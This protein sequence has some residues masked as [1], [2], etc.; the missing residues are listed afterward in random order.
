MSE[1]WQVPD[2]LRSILGYGTVSPLTGSVPLYDYE[3]ARR[4]RVAK[5]EAPEA[6]LS[7]L[8]IDE[9][10]VAE[11]TALIEAEDVA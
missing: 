9:N 11:Q 1:S 6:L 5:T 4:Q 7:R 3:A 8:G 10:T 2:F